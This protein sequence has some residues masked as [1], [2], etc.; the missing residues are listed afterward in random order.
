MK[1]FGLAVT[2]GILAVLA[3]AGVSPAATI[4]DVQAVQFNPNQYDFLTSGYGTTGYYLTWSHVDSVTNQFLTGSPGREF[5][6]TAASNP[7]WLNFS[8][9]GTGGYGQEIVDPSQNSIPTK[10]TYKLGVNTGSAWSMDFSVLFYDPA[11]AG[12]DMS[13]ELLGS[14]DGTDNYKARSLAAADVLGGTMVKY[15]IDADAG[16]TVLVTITSNGDESYAAGFF[17][18]NQS[19][20]DGMT[21]EPATLGFLLLGAG[22]LLARRRRR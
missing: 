16:E 15:H 7:A 17:M 13:I 4:Q 19:V 14:I 22:S 8:T 5:S 20:G 1:R 12:S 18:D 9:V 3:L 11:F 21:P 10:S 2:A 6:R